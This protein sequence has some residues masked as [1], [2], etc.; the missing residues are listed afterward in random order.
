MDSRWRGRDIAW[1]I[2]ASACARPALSLGMARPLDPDLAA[3][4]AIHDRP[5]GAL[6][7]ALREVVLEEAPEAIEQLF[8]NHGSAIW[9]GRGGK[10]QDMA[11]YIAMASKHVNLGLCRGAALPDPAG[12][13]EGT[14]K[15]MR[16]IK[17]RSIADLHRPF[18]RPYIRA[19]WSAA[20]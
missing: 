18:V 8:R 9:Y 12:V 1:R 20:E 11:L 4:L 16:H 10:M 3:F 19:A 7:L 15:S 14:G 13:I 6:A 2:G 5:T 17:F